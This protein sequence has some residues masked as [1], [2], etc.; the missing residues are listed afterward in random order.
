MV[1]SSERTMALYCP[2]CERLQ[3]HTFSLFEFGISPR[4][5]QCKCGFTQG[6]VVKKRRRYEV[7]LLCPSGVRVRLLYTLREFWVAPL[8][9]FYSLEDQEVLGFLGDSGEVDSAVTSWNSDGLEEDEFLEPE[10]MKGILGHLQKLAAGEHI[11]CQCDYPSVGIDV[12]PD[13]VE[14]VCS[15]CG[16]AILMGATTQR[17]SDRVSEL[18]EVIMEPSS[19]TFLD[20]CLKPLF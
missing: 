5:F 2:A 11:S 4:P 7:R 9:T 20:E 14:L 10:I 3:Y 19:Y 13:K 1:L 18:A 8:L 6:Q 17:D 15:H 12:Y 16:S